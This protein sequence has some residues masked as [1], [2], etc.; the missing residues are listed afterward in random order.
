[1]TRSQNQPDPSRLGTVQELADGYRLRFERH[2]QHPIEKVWAALTTPTKRAEWFAPGEME[3][4]LG[5][6]VAL[7]FTDGN[8][9]IDGEVTALEPPRLLEFTW[10]DKGDD[11]GFVRWELSREDGGTHLVLTHTLSETAR[12]FGLPALAGWHTLLENLAVLL[13]GQLPS[14][15]PDRW[16]EFHDHYA[17]LGTMGA[18]PDLKGDP[19]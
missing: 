9:V 14:D 7:A 16:Q 10:T 13:D 12:T 19:Q 15:L 8:T 3:L 1:V 6:R 2:F 17:E 4:T 18:Q 5:G 11:L